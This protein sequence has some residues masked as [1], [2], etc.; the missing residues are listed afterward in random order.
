M[1]VEVVNV[2][3][4]ALDYD[5]V[6][7]GHLDLPVAGAQNDIHAVDVGGWVLG[8]TSPV[9]SVERWSPDM[10]SHWRLHDLTSVT[11]IP[12][13]VDRPDVAVHHPVSHGVTCGFAASL[14][15]IGHPLE[16]EWLRQAVLYSGVGVARR[17]RVAAHAPDHPSRWRQRRAQRSSM[18]R[19]VSPH[20]PLP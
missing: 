16:F 15:V 3:P 5:E 8:R 14:G 13:T 1:A 12:I 9:G 7:D 17:A 4:H 2:E 20:A 11:R 10:A 6:A 18:T 19:V